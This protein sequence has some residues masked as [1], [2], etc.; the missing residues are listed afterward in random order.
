MAHY[1]IGLTRTSDPQGTL[2]HLDAALESD[3]H[4]VDAVQLRALVRARLG[5]RS[6]FDDVDFLVKAPTAQPLYNAASALAVY[7][8]TA[9]TA[10]GGAVD[11]APRACVQGRLFH[12]DRHGRPRSKDAP[13]SARLCQAD[14]TVL[15][16]FP[17]P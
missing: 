14:R 2:K 17:G 12:P 5:D 7:A 1:G 4:L 6:M 3:P 15:V 11:S 8:E 10:P 9:Q 16:L 13:I